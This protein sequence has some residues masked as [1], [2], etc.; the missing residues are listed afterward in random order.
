MFCVFCGLN[1]SVFRVFRGS[2][3]VI[4]LR[5]DRSKYSVDCPK[6][7]FIRVHSWLL[8]LHDFISCNNHVF[9]GFRIDV[10]AR[11]RDV[12]RLD[13]RVVDNLYVLCMRQIEAA[14]IVLRRFALL[15]IAERVVA[16]RHV[17][18][19]ADERH[20]PVTVCERVVFK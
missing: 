17:A 20:Q 8:F 11:L 15:R 13:V 12:R 18:C 14:A 16:E 7:V 6:L 3:R 5:L 2:S 4:W 10:N 1:F 19:G 9:N